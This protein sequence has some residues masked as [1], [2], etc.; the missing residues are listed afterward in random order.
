ML[1]CECWGSLSR[2]PVS[3][4]IDGPCVSLTASLLVPGVFL[5]VSALDA[6]VFVV[7][8]GAG[9]WAAV[10]DAI[11]VNGAGEV[12]VV[13]VLCV[14]VCS[15]GPEGL[16]GCCGVV[17]PDF[18]VFAVP[19]VVVR[20]LVWRFNCVD[21]VGMSGEGWGIGEATERVEMAQSK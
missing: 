5:H 16:E 18:D 19:E 11:V 7:S 2:E 1:F 17:L 10:D 15:S 12:I 13:V 3:S 14:V 8:R 4:A 21:S 9:G 20:R 6:A